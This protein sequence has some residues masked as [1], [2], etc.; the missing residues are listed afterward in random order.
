LFIQQ[1]SS[2]VWTPDIANVKPHSQ[3]PEERAKN[4]FAFG[5]PGTSPQAS[6]HSRKYEKQKQGVCYVEEDICEVMAGRIQAIKLAI[7]HV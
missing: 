5:D 3:Y 1:I 6:G 4:I 2:E 7:Q